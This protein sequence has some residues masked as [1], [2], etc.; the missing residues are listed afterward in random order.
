MNSAKTL[1]PGPELNA[2]ALAFAAA[3]ERGRLELGERLRQASQGVAILEVDEPFAVLA[4]IGAD[5]ATPLHNELRRRLAAVA[6]DVVD[7]GAFRFLLIGRADH[8]DD[9]RAIARAARET[10]S[11]PYAIAGRSVVLM[12]VAG[13]AF[14]RAGDDALSALR[15]AAAALNEARRRGRRLLADDE[16]ALG[17]ADLAVLAQ[18]VSEVERAMTESR[19]RLAL[20]PV[21]DARTRRVLH[22]EALL[23]VMDE[24]GRAVSAASLIAT[25]ETL[26]FAHRVDLAVLDLAARAL[27]ADPELKL[28]INISAASARDRTQACKWLARLARFGEDVRRVTVE[29]T[30]TAAPDDAAGAV[31]SFAA[32]VRGLGAAFSIDDF[33]AGYTSYRSL[34]ALG[35][36]EVKIDGWF[37][38][39][40]RRDPR[41]GAFVKAL[42]GLAKELGAR[43]VAEWVETV[44]DADALTQLGVDA[45]QGIYFG[46]PTIRPEP[47]VHAP[48]RPSYS[49]L[50]LNAA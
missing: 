44:E 6:D 43:T 21:L 14:A 4:N 35:P 28:A 32:A 48:A 33:G 36:D 12:A 3:A 26:E 38:R 27:A 1:D 8:V 45:L 39:E 2:C 13:A 34:L 50:R 46:E 10:V 49:G 29:L 7:I 18:S 23:R 40:L 25:A 24:D 5:A 31:S 15:N 41:A 37:V 17:H 30:E 16:L 9:A 47:S 42:V 22:H 20:Q 19:F 11:E